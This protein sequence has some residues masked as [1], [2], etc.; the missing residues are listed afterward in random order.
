MRPLSFALPL[1]AAAL[2]ASAAIAAPDGRNGGDR[3]PRGGQGVSDGAS[4][5]MMRDSGPRMDRGDRGGDRGAV[6]VDRDRGD[7]QVERNRGDRGDVR[8]DRNRGDRYDAPRRRWSDGDRGR[9]N[10]RSGRRYNWAP[11]FAFY[12][13]DGYYYGDCNWLRRKARQTGSP[14]WIER[15]ERCR[16]AS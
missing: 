7:R 13:T 14:I 1:M 15:Y 12:F 6:R 10:W 16:W 9:R 11:G 4:K 2:M 5:S 8:V 3:G